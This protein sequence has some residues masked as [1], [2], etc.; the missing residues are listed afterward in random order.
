MSD[1][2]R[3]QADPQNLRGRV[4]DLLG[5]GADMLLPWER[6]ALI[7]IDG[8]LIRRTMG[9]APIDVPVEGFRAWFRAQASEGDL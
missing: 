4:E 3:P 8:N 7:K 6:A 1:M 9:L 5:I 2:N